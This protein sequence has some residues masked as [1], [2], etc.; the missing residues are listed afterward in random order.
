MQQIG[1][2]KDYRESQD[3]QNVVRRIVTICMLPLVEMD[4]G[5]DLVA[6]Y[7]KDFPFDSRQRKLL[8][9]LLDYYR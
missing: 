1:L 7:V 9:S 4:F 5:L 6:E 8:R 3:I 2:S